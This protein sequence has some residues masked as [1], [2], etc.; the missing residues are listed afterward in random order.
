MSIENNSDNENIEKNVGLKPNLQVASYIIFCFNIKKIIVG[1]ILIICFSFAYCETSLASIDKGKWI[2]VKDKMDKMRC[3]V[4]A[5]LLPDG[6]VLIMGGEDE[7]ADT[8]EIF[9]PKQ[10]KI[11]KSIPL[12]DKRFYGF[13]AISLRNGD[14][15]VINGSHKFSN[16][17]YPKLF[18]SKTYK[19]IDLPEKIFSRE[20]YP[21]LLKNGNVLIVPINYAN[22]ENSKKEHP[23]QIYDVKTKKIYTK[24]TDVPVA[25]GAQKFYFTL[26]NGDIVFLYMKKK[27]IYRN[28]EDKFEEF[29]IDNGQDSRVKVQINTKEYLEFAPGDE[30][31]K[32]HIYNII[33][34]Q[35]RTVTNTIPQT[36]R[37]PAPIKTI[38][39]D[40]GNIFIIG[41]NEKSRKNEYQNIK[42]EYKNK[43]KRRYSAYIY[44]KDK[45]KFYE[46][47]PLPIPVTKA[48][49][50]K[51]KN[52]DVLVAGGG[53][54]NVKRSLT[55][56]SN[57]IQIY[58]YKH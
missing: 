15:L 40:N 31:T 52:G 7:S 5:N 20:V 54:R 44:N 11:I 45:N 23:Y 4:S 47:F 46:V 26:D 8:A 36:C 12:T 34:G 55:E 37:F 1:I 35:E 25:I 18:D 32:G 3:P 28:E 51:L 48:G 14:V 21:I 39:L 22:F 17:E 50:V 58:K 57:R 42:Q 41:I 30:N 9:D 6:N 24:E 33:N 16:I 49:I 19:F 56:Y 2:V 38:L 53:Y 13:N 29:G 10:M 27:Y 43:L